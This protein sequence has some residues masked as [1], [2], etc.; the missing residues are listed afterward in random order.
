MKE[1]WWTAPAIAESGRTVL[2]TGRDY[3]D[4]VIAKNKYVNR[5]TVS[6]DYDALPTGMPSDGDA[7]L[8]QQVTDA[9]MSA[10]KRDKVAYLTGIYTGDGKRE[11][12]FYTSNL[13]IF[14]KVFN[15]AL[16]NL[17]LIPLVIEAE[18]DPEWNEY[19]EMREISYIAEDENEI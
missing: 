6:L 15:R 9:F 5:I 13:F 11:W 17:P 18:A 10:F 16:E 2:V 4:E 8:M 12:V 7:E 14:Q 19:R 3:M 1:R